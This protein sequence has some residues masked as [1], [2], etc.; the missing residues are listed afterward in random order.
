MQHHNGVE[1]KWHSLE[2]GEDVLRVL[3]NV[4]RDSH[5]RGL[6]YQNGTVGLGV[7]LEPTG[8]ETVEMAQQ[9][10]DCLRKD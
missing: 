8:Q 5:S 4:K 9:G 1:R 7:A 6:T 2:T 10:T 3:L